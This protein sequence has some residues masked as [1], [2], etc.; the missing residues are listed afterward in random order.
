VRGLQR[1]VE[2]DHERDEWA[3]RAATVFDTFNWENA[4]RNMISH[5]GLLLDR[6]HA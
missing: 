4:S 1:V 6:L 2:F 3:G 5:F